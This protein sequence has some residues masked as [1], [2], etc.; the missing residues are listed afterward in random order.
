MCG[1]YRRTAREEELAWIYHIPIPTQLDLP[2][3]EMT[4]FRHHAT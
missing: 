1:R 3:G 2:I 4:G